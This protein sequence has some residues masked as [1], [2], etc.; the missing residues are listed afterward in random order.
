MAIVRKRTLVGLGA[1]LVVG[2]WSTHHYGLD[3]WIADRTWL[4]DADAFYF[5][6]ISVMIGVVLILTAVFAAIWNR[7]DE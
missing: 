5:V 2:G 7:K 6:V 4:N 1:A 3:E